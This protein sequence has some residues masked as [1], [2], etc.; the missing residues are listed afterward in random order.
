MKKD[1]Y[2][3]L[4]IRQLKALISNQTRRTGE[5]TSEFKNKINIY[6]ILPVFKIFKMITICHSSIKKW[7][8]S[9]KTNLHLWSHL[10]IYR[11]K[12]M[13]KTVTSA[14][15]TVVGVRNIMIAVQVGQRDSMKKQIH[16]SMRMFWS[17]L[18]KKKKLM[19]SNLNFK[20]D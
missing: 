11:Y 1:L 17:N 5:I 12:T 19:L 4:T 3:L 10:S 14:V 9:I 16:F 6:L 18:F 20:W 2:L 13:E 8:R 7:V 15:F